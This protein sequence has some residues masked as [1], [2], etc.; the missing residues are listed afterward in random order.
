MTICIGAIC[1]NGKACVVAADREITVPAINLEFEHADKKIEDVVSGCVVM[2]SGDALLASQII[3]R[4]RSTLGGSSQKVDKV[5]ERLRDTYKAIHLERA[6]NVIL[7]PRGFTL[8]EFKE[9]GAQIPAQAYLNLDQSLF[10]FGI[11]AVEFLVAG[12]DSTGAHIFRIHYSGVAGGDWMEWCD[13]LGYRTIGSGS[14][15]ASISLALEGQ[16]RRLSAAETLYNVYSAK[17]NSEVAPGVGKATDI[18]ILT[19]GKVD[20]VSED[21]IKKLAEVRERHIKDKPGNTELD[22]I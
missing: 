2:S 16:H 9:R 6:E 19:T 4:T 18:V 17:R 10:N 14:S 5:A 11:G 1:D 12:V 3:E 20:S 21:R 15:H 13:R 8:K 22:G 7:H